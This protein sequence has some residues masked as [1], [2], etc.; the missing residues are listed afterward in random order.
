VRERVTGADE[1]LIG[2]PAL[3]LGYLD[4]P[5]KTAE[6]FRTLDGERFFH[7]G[8]RVGRAED[9]QLLHRGRLDGEVKINGIRVDPGEVETEI[10]GHPDV[11]AVAVVG[12][13]VAARTALVA[14]VV[15]KTGADAE[16]LGHGVRAYLRDRVPGHLVPSR[17]TVV[18]GLVL[19]TS[20]KVD[21]MG[22]HHRH[23]S[24][25]KEANS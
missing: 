23:T 1:L 18:D 16:S 2:G 8:D 22:S 15:P 5:E 17:V 13:T 6:R 20:G 3:A 25:A 19:T 21:R 24:P 7:T 9:G 10:S 12:V 14:Y 11:L 4:L